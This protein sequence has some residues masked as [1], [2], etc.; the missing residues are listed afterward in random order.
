MQFGARLQ[1]ARFTTPI[2]SPT[3][4][5]IGKAKRVTEQEWLGAQM[6]L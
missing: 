3:N 6:L 1:Q 2:H 4:D 5:D